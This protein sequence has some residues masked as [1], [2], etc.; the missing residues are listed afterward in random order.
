MVSIQHEGEHICGGSIISNT[1]VITAA[2]CVNGIQLSSLK[3]LVGTKKLSLGGSFYS[4]LK[5]KV[6]ENFNSVTVKNDISLLETGFID[7]TDSVGPVQLD[8][9]HV[10]GNQV[11]IL[12]G[13]GYTTNEVIGNKIPDNLQQIY[14]KTI[15]VQQ[16][17][18]YK[19]SVDENQICTFTKA[20][21]GFCTHDSGSSLVKIDRGVEKQ[22][23][24]ASW[25]MACARGYP[26]VYTRISAYFTWIKESCSC[27]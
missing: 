6:H 13:W 21:E 8:F 14:V 5:L 23:G 16:C 15:T 10:L 18:D 17:Q 2:H 20:G 12:S 27:I 9:E 4:I 22:I 3:V 25:M 26:D 19:L 1:W 11:G 24:I 7:Y